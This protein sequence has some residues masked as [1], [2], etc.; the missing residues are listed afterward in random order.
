MDGKLKAAL[1]SMTVGEL[2]LL[3]S[4]WEAQIAIL[5]VVTE[6]L[7]MIDTKP[8]GYASETLTD[9]IGANIRHAKEILEGKLV[10]VDLFEPHVVNG[11]V[12]AIAEEENDD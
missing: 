9:Q 7:R 12:V 6:D 5:R 2:R 3:V 4:N 10:K 8:R 11:R 1:D